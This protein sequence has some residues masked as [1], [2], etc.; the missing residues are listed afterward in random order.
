[1]NELTRKLDTTYRELAGRDTVLAGVLAEYG[2][3]DP[4]A[5]HDGGRAGASKFAAMLLHIVGQRISAASAFAVYDKIAERTGSPPAAE[6]ISRLGVETLRVCGLSAARADYA[7]AL[8]NAELSGGLGLEHLDTVPDDDVIVR[9]TA[10]RGIGLW[11]A[12]TF[13]IHNLARPDVLPEGD[14]GVRE[15]IRRLWR[16]ESL[17]GPAAVRSRGTAWAPFRSYAAALLWR[18][19]RPPGEPSDPKERALHG[20]RP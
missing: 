13:L 12:Q 4:F 6:S 5:W 7:V 8:A 18:S 19:L 11:S 20:L 2:P 9:L 1:V 3:Q 15:A 10:V 14:N 17:P 16:L